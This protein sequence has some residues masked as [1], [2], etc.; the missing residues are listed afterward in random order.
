MNFTKRI[1]KFMLV[2]AIALPA[3]HASVAQNNSVP[4]EEVAVPTKHETCDVLESD[5]HFRLPLQ[6][7]PNNAPLVEKKIETGEQ[8]VAQPMNATS[9]N[10]NRNAI[11]PGSNVFKIKAGN[12]VGLPVKLAGKPMKTS[13]KRSNAKGNVATKADIPD[14]YVEI[15]FHVENVWN[16]GS[17]YQLLIGSESSLTSATTW[18]DIYSAAVYSVPEKAD[19]S[20]TGNA[21]NMIVEGTQSIMIPAGTYDYVVTNP[22]PGDKTYRSTYD[23]YTFNAGGSYE[24][25]IYSNNGSETLDINVTEPASDVV[26]V[27]TN[28][29][30]SPDATTATISW[31]SGE[32]NESWNLRYRE[33]G[34]VYNK[35]RFWDFESESQIDDFTMLDIDG[36]GYNWGRNGGSASLKVQSGSYIMQSASYLNNIGALTPNNWLITPKVKLGG[37]VSFYACGQDNSDYSEKFGVYVFQGGT[38]TSVND[39]AQVGN[40]RTTGSSMTKYTFDLSSYSGP[41]YIAIVHHNTTDM[42]FLNIDDIEVLVP[43]ALPDNEWIYVNDVTNPY[44]ITGLTT[45][46]TYEVQVQGVGNNTTTDWTASEIFTTLAPTQ[47]LDFGTVTVNSS[48][49]LDAMLLNESSSAVQATIT[50]NPNPPFSV[51]STTS[52]TVTLAANTLTS[53]PVT[54]APTEARN[55]NG[56]LTVVA[57]DVTTT[58][59]LKG[60]GNMSG[61]E[62]LRDSAFFADITYEWTDSLD[63]TH[64]SRL[65]EIATDPD[66]IIAMIREV[67][68]NRNIPGNYKRG[69]T[70]TGS[71]EVYNDVNYAGVGTLEL[72]N[73]IVDYANGYGWNIPGDVITKTTTNRLNYSVDYSFMDSTQ[74]KPHNEGVTLLLLEINDV[75]NKKNVTA[76]NKSLRDYIKSAL[77]SARIVTQSKRTGTGLDKG[78]LFKIDCDKMNKFYLIAKGQLRWIHNSY[79]AE[80]KR[81]NTTYALH[82]TYSANPVYVNCSN[83]P[84]ANGFYD[85][86]SFQLFYNMFEEFS[87]VAND[88]ATAKGDIYQDLVNMESFGVEHDCM[89]VPYMGHQ[90]QMYGEDSD[91]ADC[92]D[93]RDMMFFVPDYRMMY[94]YKIENGDTLSRDNKKA[95][96]YQKFMNYNRD[97]QPTMGL[98]VIRQD[99]ITTTTE[100]DDY[101]M[102]D[103]HWRTNLDN[104]LP[105]DEQEYYLYE[106]VT[107]ENGTHYEHVYYRNVNGEYTD[108]QGNVLPNQDDPTTWVPIVLQMEA[109][110]VKSYPY[111]YVER[112]AS[113]K[114]VTYAIQGCDTGHFLSL[115][116]SNQMSYIIPGTDPNEMLAVQDATHYSR[117]NPQ[118]VKNCYSNKIQ[119]SNNAMGLNNNNI[120]DG[121][122]GTKLFVT[123]S[124]MTRVNNLPVS[125]TDTVATITFNNH[126]SS[127]NRSITVTM[128]KQSPKSEYPNGKSSGE[129]AGYHA[130]KGETSWTQSYKISTN[131]SNRNNVIFDPAL[132][133]FDNFT[134]DVSQN[135]H[136]I[137]YTYQIVT[138]YAGQDNETVYSNMY[139]VPVYKTGSQ[140]NGS[141]TKEEVDNDDDIGLSLA[142]NVEFGTQVQYSSKTEILR[143][144]AYRWDAK[145]LR[146][147]VDSIYT[148]GSELDLPPTGIAG[149][150]GG[151]YTVSMNVVGTD[152]YTTSTVSVGNGQ[153]AWANFVDP[154]PLNANE[155]KAYTYAP[156]VE[157]FTTGKD[158]NNKTRTDYNTYGGPLQN[159]AA[160]LLDVSVVE[161]SAQVPLMSNFDWTKDGKKYA[162]YQIF[163]NVNTAQVPQG[164][165]LYGIRAW[166]HVSQDLLGEHPLYP[167]PDRVPTDDEDIMFEKILNGYNADDYFILGS[168]PAEYSDL[169]NGEVRATFGA[170]KLRTKGGEETGVIDQLNAE[171]T[172]RLY[173]TPAPIYVYANPG[174][175]D[176][177]CNNAVATLYS[178]DGKTYTGTVTIPEGSDHTGYF[179]FSKKVGSSWT[180]NNQNIFGAQWNDAV[181]LVGP[182]GPNNIWE[183]NL[184]YWSGETRSFKITPGTYKFEITNHIQSRD[185]SS[186]A[187]WS[188]GN[189]KITPVTANAGLRDGAAGATGKFYVAEQELNFSIDSSSE[190]ITGIFD[191]D[192]AKQV[193][194]VKYYNVAGI[195]SDKPFDGINIVVTRYSDGSVVTRKEVK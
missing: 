120:T 60:I 23:T 26:G 39:F 59:P 6:L 51:A 170:R 164:Y 50:V 159:T 126:H 130:N 161:P 58:I 148:D 177:D 54:F 149:N 132:T 136:P 81:N 125:V 49:T 124:Y 166:R 99:S 114:E 172:V 61:P 82:D 158:E 129:G 178:D 135:D 191:I 160:G 41:G 175:N 140:I 35:N 68:T 37:S 75:F 123:R 14:G 78:T 90:F 121:N 105:S 116:M 167:R 15:V 22:T 25:H 115:Q 62:A 84:Y 107:D 83:Y 176:I 183:F 168:A 28:L 27:P 147:I 57:G 24:F 8:N 55:Y 29:E 48:E 87:P 34:D 137:G 7:T 118:S 80:Y 119:V 66:Q 43:D 10:V 146:F 38:W 79:F 36:D 179:V 173:F 110:Q 100:A 186:S 134:V 189:L 97:H 77:K 171:F 182:Q 2:A 101:Y 42:F 20:S 95:L 91:A 65:D 5:S 93:V 163:L 21:T 150:Q 139:R 19:Y 16:D 33:V 142:D 184:R 69:F 63:N 85:D 195:E 67:Y 117:F 9:S 131:S 86:R 156:V 92:Q 141:F 74:Y 162:Y 96:K 17:G 40:D 153:T 70:A 56:T 88:A 73:G 111:V 104:F 180:S 181:A 44:T 187:D 144:D 11:S 94:Y 106:V 133:I 185:L 64:V 112:E 113:S 72:N 108:A 169:Q 194:G 151:S 45:G 174:G 46:T 1:I 12:T 3:W 32:N 157:L 47:S 30:A 138:N 154:I 155:A 98:Y 145:E 76:S 71:D 31:V 122:D 165:S 102:L 143:Y 190:I 128:A 193:A 188:A 192:G 109:G 127:S 103:L 4:P 52:T 13:V 18:S 53:V 152:D 89:G